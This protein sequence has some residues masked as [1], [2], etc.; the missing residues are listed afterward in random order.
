MIVVGYR[1]VVEGLE[2]SAY[3][4]KL[5]KLKSKTTQVPVLSNGTDVLPFSFF[6]LGDQSSKSL[7]NVSQEIC[8]GN[9]V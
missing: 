6:S 9:E 7:G 2:R 3:I 5:E 8:L 4:W 1:M